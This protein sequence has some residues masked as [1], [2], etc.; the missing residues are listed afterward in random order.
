MGMVVLAT[1]HAAT[2]A[3]ADTQAVGVRRRTARESLRARAAALRTLMQGMAS[4]VAVRPWRRIQIGF[5]TMPSA[6]FFSTEARG[7]RGWTTAERQCLI[8]EETER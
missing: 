4:H 8:G 3:A 6:F 7:P 5:A 1:W 2:A